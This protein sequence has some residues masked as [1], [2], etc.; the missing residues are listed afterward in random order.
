MIMDEINFTSTK[1]QVP[2]YKIEPNEV[3]FHFLHGNVPGHQIDFMY[4]PEVPQPPLT[5]QHFSH[6]ARLVKYIEPRHST[7][8]SFAIT[9]LSRDDNQH[10]PGHGG[11]AFVFGLRI[12]GVRD[13]AGRQDPPFCHAA[14][15]IDRQLDAA[16][17]HHIAVQFHKKLLPVE[18]SEVEGSGWYRSQYVPHAE[19]PAHVEVILRTYVKDF[20]DLYEPGPSRQTWRW[21]VD[22]VTVPRRVTIVYP[23]RVDFST[24]AACMARI[25]EVLLE[26]NIKWTA[27]SN[28][29]EQDVSGGLT[30]R[31]VPRREATEASADEVLLYLEHVPDQP[32]EIATHLFNAHEVNAGPRLSRLPP[33]PPAAMNRPAGNHETSKADGIAHHGFDVA[34]GAHAAGENAVKPWERLEPKEAEV[35]EPPELRTQGLGIVAVVEKKDTSDGLGAATE[36]ASEYKKNERKQ[37]KQ[38]ATALAATVLFILIFGGLALIMLLSAPKPV[39]DEAV[40]G[41]GKAVAPIKSAKVVGKTAPTTAAL[42]KS[43]ASTAGAMPTTNSSSTIHFQ[44]TPITPSTTRKPNKKGTKT[45]TIP[46]IF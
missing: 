13:H 41:I 19:N 6:L 3:W 44:D 8:Y 11:V 45:D 7:A 18:E 39:V 10:E 1:Y 30:V 26:S 24:L 22:G 34:H 29:R 33:P 9:N 38:T 28:G 43:V 12:N 5:R 16:T 46:D 36:W 20:D 17:L 42:P 2:E 32:S 15:L 21:S 23:D 27:V 14:A 25:T 31:F 4:R 40:A 37:R 35:S